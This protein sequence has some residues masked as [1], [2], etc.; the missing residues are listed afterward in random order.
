MTNRDIIDALLERLKEKP[1]DLQMLKD[2]FSMARLVE[3]EDKKYSHDI[4]KVVRENTA[5]ATAELASLDHFDLYKQSLLFVARDDFDSYLQYIE[6]EREPE[7]RFYLPRRKQLKVVVDA[8][9]DMVDDK[10]DLLTVSMPPGTG[11]ST[12]GIYFLSW[13]IGRE[14]L[15]CNLAS[16]H[17]AKLTRSFYDGVLS[18]MTDPEYLYSDVF[19]E[20]RIVKTSAKD[21]QIHV[22]KKQ[23]FPSLTCR[24]IDGGLTGATRCENILYADDL[25]TGIEEALSLERMDTLWE[26]YTNDLKSRKKEY[27]KEIH[28]ATRWSV[29]DPI[30]RLE[31]EYGDN[32]RARFIVLPALDEND[33]S[34]FDYPYGVG[35]STKYFH[36][37]RNNLDDISWRALYMNQPIEREGLVFPS[38][39]LNR[40]YDL[41]REEPDGIIAVCDTAEGGGDSVC[42]PI[43]YMYGTKVYIEDVIMDNSLPEVTKPRVTKALLRN[44]VH[45]AEFESNSA[46]GGYA[47]DI[48]DEIKKH[49]G[50]THITKR[51]TTTNKLTK[52]IM[53]SDYIKE[54]FY[55][56]DSKLYSPKSD[57]GRYMKEL[58]GF[59]HRGKV[60]HDDAPDATAQLSEFIK[61]MNL[62]K[63]EVIQRPI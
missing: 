10:I 29:H 55:F 58:T 46:G 44:R 50:I 6:I 52:I 32:D 16:A 42:L 61:R 25:V 21:E 4:N 23:R 19:P 57:Y 28:I 27:A 54:N 2:L 22:N 1:Y 9:Q 11:K 3:K 34:N 51:K 49:Q 13:V 62:G 43:G 40:Y 63:V 12:L 39:E 20:N 48:R 38:D 7:K 14:P 5:K 17:G 60:K 45:K 30:G 37:M 47:D 53:N 31:V 18:I 35:F 26:K 8:M 24:S 36:D 59:T 56:K 41:P 15:K 33:E